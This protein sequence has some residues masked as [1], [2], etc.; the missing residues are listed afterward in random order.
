M[1]RLVAIKMLPTYMMNA[2]AAARF[3]REVQA[4]ARLRHPNVV[5]ADDSDCANG[6]HKARILGKQRD[7]RLGAR[8]EWRS[9]GRTISRNPFGDRV[10]FLIQCGAQ[11]ASAA[12]ERIRKGA[13]PGRLAR[14]GSLG[15]RLIGR[16][17]AGRPMV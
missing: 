10:A 17:R 11:S 6:V 15:L 13:A 16:R 12:G 1:K 9:V 7:R 4:A 2:A 3:Q 14:A 8:L 5:A